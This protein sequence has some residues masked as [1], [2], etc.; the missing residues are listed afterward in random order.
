MRQV[1][2]AGSESPTMLFSSRILKN[3]VSAGNHFSS[4]LTLS[5][6]LLAF[7][8]FLVEYVSVKMRH[9]V[10]KTRISDTRGDDRR[11]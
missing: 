7:K 10:L 1:Q 3:S 6:I 5:L 8:H 4:F 9:T 11:C 2:K